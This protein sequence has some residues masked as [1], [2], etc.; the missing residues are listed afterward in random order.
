MQLN[1][2]SNDHCYHKL[3]GV[4]LRQIPISIGFLLL[5]FSNPKGDDGYNDSIER[6]STLCSVGRIQRV[7]IGSDS[8]RQCEAVF[9]PVRRETDLY[10]FFHQGERVRSFSHLLRLYILGNPALG[11]TEF[12]P[13]N[14]EFHISPIEYSISI[15]RSF[16]MGSIGLIGFT[17]VWYA[18]DVRRAVNMNDVRQRHYWAVWSPMLTLR[19]PRVIRQLCEQR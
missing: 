1:L 18:V 4:W 3:F 17:S 5:T 9:G 15:I 19:Y 11:Y 10:A 8:S 13:I 2:L 7:L 16:V 14:D 6:D 12:R